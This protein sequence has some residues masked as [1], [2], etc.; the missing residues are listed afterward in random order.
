MQYLKR[1]TPSKQNIDPQAVLDLLRYYDK[2]Q[3]GVHSIMIL[4]HDQVV[5]EAWWA[6]YRPSYLNALF[7]MSKSFTST[8]VGFAV[9]EG[10]MSVSD[11]LIDYFPDE[12]PQDAEPCGYMKQL[13]I[14]DTLRMATGHVVEPK[15]K[16]PD[17]KTW[18]FQFLSSYIEK[19][20]GSH[21]LY[22]T[23][24]S[25]MLSAAV[26]K[27][28]GMTVEEYL[29][30]R[31]FEPLGF[32]EHWWEESPEGVSAGGYGFNLCTEDI[33]KFGVFLLRR[34]AYGGKQLLDPQWVDEATA[35]QM[36]FTAHPNIDSRQGYG[37]QFWRC[38]PEGSY[39]AAGAFAQFCIVLP[40]QDMVIA[41]TSGAQDT[42]P[43]LTALWEI[44]LPG[45]DRLASGDAEKTE[46]ELSGFAAGVTLSMPRGAAHSE[47]EALYAACEYRLSDNLLGIDTVSFLPEREMKVRFTVRGKQSVL[48]AP[49]G[50]WADGQ[51]DGVKNLDFHAA[52]PM[53]DRVACSGGWESPD[54]FTLFINYPC[55]PFTDLLTF[56]FDGFGFTLRH[57]RKTGFQLIDR[58]YFG[59]PVTG[60][61]ETAGD[62]G[63]A[64]A[65][66][67][68]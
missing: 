10:K 23:A 21:Y 13:T 1:S 65:E 30:P 4:R 37:Y 3:T 64:S 33:A 22:N 60:A 25:Y 18:A 49:C 19:T 43:V 48:P 7:S 12:L 2:H 15:L 57:Q 56:S 55:T 51:L 31:L 24:G 17:G 53:D 52:A 62:G 6:P 42:Q 47:K 50:R 68:F 54:R 32:G 36:E 45:V 28:V 16:N 11:R 26:Q 8:A 39:R 61:E 46:R 35:K 27:A 58:V 41:V 29:A 38:Q 67:R 44:L 63:T 20:P 5:A 34:G 14:R 40:K 9:Q 66:C 59:R